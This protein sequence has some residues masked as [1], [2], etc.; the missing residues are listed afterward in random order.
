MDDSRLRIIVIGSLIREPTGGHA[1]ANLSYVLGLAALDHDVY[2][3]E[4]SDDYPTCYDP[5]ISAATTDPTYGL[6]FAANAL[7]RLGLGDR[8]AYYDAHTNEWKG[9]R[10]HDATALCK[11]ADLVLS[12]S[13]MW[14]NPLRDWFETVPQRAT[15]DGDP[16]FT[17]ARNL[18]DP[19][20]RKRCE[21]YTAFYTV[22]ANIGK[23]GCTIPAD[24]FPWE[25]T[26]LPISL[27]A[28]PY[29]LGPPNGRYTTVMQWETFRRPIEYGGLRL[30]NKSESFQPFVELP[31]RLGSIFEIAIRSRWTS[32]HA[33]LDQ[34]GWRIADSDSISRDPWT[35]QA[36]VQG[37]KAEF[38]IAKA[39][40]VET[41]CGWFSER[42]AAYLASGRPVLH[43]DTG[44]PD[45]LPCGTGVFAFHSQEDVVDAVSQV[46]AD[47]DVH[48]RAA[49]E[50]AAEYFSTDRVLPPLID[51]TM[52]ASAPKM[53]AFGA[54]R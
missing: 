20:F 47:Y 51:A 30:G 24:G 15:I 5:K 44:F 11:S 10:A 46:E 48:C 32:P 37:S 1:W 53:G 38:G 9:A 3:I 27:A 43:Q 26:R 54:L 19:A 35:Y 31:R 22:G 14:G 45:W 21:A 36:F 25:V 23:P 49:R 29:G 33:M 41:R 16:G 13:G 12:Y 39:G 42:S 34:A 28:W 2:Y 7:G 52:A 50:L 6:R 18:A 40:Y 8:W 17:Q 4:D